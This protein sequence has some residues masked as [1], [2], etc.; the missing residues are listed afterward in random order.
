[1][2]KTF[3]ELQDQAQQG[4]QAL[5]ASPRPRI[6]VGTAA[7]GLGA[8]AGEV[9][10]RLRREIAER[11]LDAQLYEVGCMGVC[12]AEPVVAIAKPPLPLVFYGQVTPEKTARLVQ[13]HLVEGK[14]VPD[15][16]LGSIGE[17]RADGIPPLSD[18]PVFQSQVRRVMRNC[19]LIDPAQID[20]ALAHGAYSGLQRARQLGPD[21]VIEELKRSGLRGRGGAGFPTWR[22]WQLAQQHQAPAKYVI[23]N[24]SEGDPGTFSNKLLLESDPH[25]VLEGMLIAAY[26]IGAEEAYLYCPAEYALALERLRIALRQLEQTGLWGAEVGAR[27][28]QLHLKLKVGAGAY[29]CG[30]ET[31]LIECI[32]GKRGVPRC[33]PPFPPT[34]GLW[35]CPTVVNNVETLACVALIFQHNAEWFAQLGTEKS[36]GTK[37]FCLSGN[38]RR[39]GV[40]EVPFGVSLRQLVETLG[41]GTADGSPIQA[42]FAGGPGGGCLPEY[43]LDTPADQDSLLGLGASIGS[44]GLIVIGRDACLL[45]L[46]RNSLDFARRACCGRC[47]PCRLGTQQLF[48]I[49]TDIAQGRG[50]L[51]DL[52]LL[53]DVSEAMKLGA[54]CG[55]GQTAANPMLST[56]RYFSDQYR[57]H[58]AERQ[59]PAGVCGRASAVAIRSG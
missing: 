26:A 27:P 4:W 22:K 37:L 23:C 38:V 47:V 18:T 19:G 30:E 8:G 5:E 49:L 1:M 55:L 25:S 56:L 14:T 7:C 9:L 20:H 31:A 10:Q 12:W 58:L 45:D 36:K 17:A 21:G 13:C 44:G 42:V 11:Q 2:S 41:G 46:A 16:A 29:V 35:N 15:W 3:A 40:V 33:R 24:G 6:L 51:D 48:D 32:E 43:L 39:P 57:R 54:L 52:D 28:F 34:S 53:R 59:C 50:T